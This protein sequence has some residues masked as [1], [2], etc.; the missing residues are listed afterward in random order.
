MEIDKLAALSQLLELPKIEYAYDPIPAAPHQY[1]HC[2]YR[3]STEAEPRNSHFEANSIP[4][5]PLSA[6]LPYRS[7]LDHVRASRFW[8]SNLDETVKLLQLLA[9]DK[10]SADIEVDHGIT[11]AK[12]AQKALQPGLEHQIA[13][14]AHYMFPGADEPRIVQIA[15][16]TI[17]YFIFDGQ[18]SFPSN[19]HH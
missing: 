6:G 15:A 13:L 1:N 2:L 8:Y 7:S 14:A 12:L 3:L 11:I 17:M 4:L 10:S 19:P 18:L 16:L 9:D 5:N